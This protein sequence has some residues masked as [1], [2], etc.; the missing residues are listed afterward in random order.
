MAL[1]S[2]VE[3]ALTTALVCRCLLQHDATQKF[4]SNSRGLLAVNVT[5]TI[6]DT[7]TGESSSETMLAGLEE[8]RASDAV[9]EHGTM[10]SIFAIIHKLQWKTA[11][12]DGKLF[13]S[14]EER[15]NFKL[16]CRSVISDGASTAFNVSRL[17]ELEILANVEDKLADY[18]EAERKKLLAELGTVA[19]ASCDMHN[20][21]DL[22]LPL[23]LPHVYLL[24]V[25]STDACS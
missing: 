16:L 1:F 22:F 24:L 18:P 10:K 5:R 8:T 3:K 13:N 2:T 19:I 25:Q 15:V 7:E 11:S 12:K 21:G 23:W 6:V 20:V 14:E 17:H 9:S 4:Q